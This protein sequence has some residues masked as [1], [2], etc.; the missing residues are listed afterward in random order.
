MI[1]LHKK[2]SRFL[3]ILVGKPTESLKSLDYGPT[4]KIRWDW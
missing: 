3:I 2:T 1:V 4:L